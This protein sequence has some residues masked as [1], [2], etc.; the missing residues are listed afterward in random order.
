MAELRGR[1]RDRAACPTR[2]G[3]GIRALVEPSGER[4]ERAGRELAA[5][6]ETVRKRQPGA[7][8]DLTPQETTIMR[9]AMTGRTSPEIAAAL[10]LSPGTVE[11][12]MREVRAELD[13]SSRRE[14]SEYDQ[15]LNAG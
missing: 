5:T 9:L 8:V 3:R 10:F 7:P 12:H 13:V 15:S 11:W 2:C 14:L 1:A 6:G 4:F